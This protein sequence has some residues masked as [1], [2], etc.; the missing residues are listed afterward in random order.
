MPRC[1]ELR[2]ALGGELLILGV[3]GVARQVAPPP[4][5][6]APDRAPGSPGPVERRLERPRID[7][8]ETIALLDEVA[9]VKQDL[10]RACPVT[11]ERTLIVVY[12]STL[13]MP[14]MSTG[15]SFCCTCPTT[16]GTAAPPPPRPPPR[17]AAEVRLQAD[18]RGRPR[19]TTAHA[20]SE[21]F[22][23]RSA[24]A[25]FFYDSH[26]EYWSSR[27]DIYPHRPA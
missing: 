13:P 19:Q 4:A 21:R 18:R 3:R 17:G 5:R 27:R 10:H 11:C 22:G 7:R 15:T 26:S 25:I 6:A 12:A 20:I 9:F 8:E 1:D 24:P 14:S 23:T 16:T 2:L